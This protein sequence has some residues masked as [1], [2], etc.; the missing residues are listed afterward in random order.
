MTRAVAEKS[1]IIM[2]CMDTSQ[3]V[4]GGCG[5]EEGVIAGLSDG[6]IVIGFWHIIACGHQSL[7]SEVVK[8]S[9]DKADGPLAERSQHAKQG[10]AF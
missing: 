4:E 5:G 9:C 8:R 7:T 2:L 1:D 10:Q 3:S 6:K